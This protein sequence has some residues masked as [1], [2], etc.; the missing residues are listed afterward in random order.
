MRHK[1]HTAAG[2]GDGS[3]QAAA[4]GGGGGGSGGRTVQRRSRR[5]EMYDHFCVSFFLQYPTTFFS[6]NYRG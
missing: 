3:R 5:M 4:V 1:C 6:P 2:G